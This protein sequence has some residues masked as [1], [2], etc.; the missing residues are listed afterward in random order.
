VSELVVDGK[1]ALCVRLEDGMFMLCEIDDDASERVKN[2][3][4]VRNV[5]LVLGECP[6]CG[7]CG[8][9]PPGE[10]FRFDH[11]DR[12]RALLDDEDQ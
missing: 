5:A 4:A 12:C 11:E 7:A 2:A 10:A 3:L 8:Y 9:L 1:G 6:E